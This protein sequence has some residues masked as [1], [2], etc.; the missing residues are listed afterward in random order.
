MPLAYVTFVGDHDKEDLSRLL[1]KAPCELSRDMEVHSRI[2]LTV[3]QVP[4]EIRSYGSYAHATGLQ[5]EFERPIS[6]RRSYG[7]HHATQS[8]TD[9]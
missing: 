9:I 5:N 6:P 1:I 2:I 8:A 3:G 7:C 4:A